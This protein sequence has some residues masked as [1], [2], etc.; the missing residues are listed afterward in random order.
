[1]QVAKDLPPAIAA[2]YARFKAEQAAIQ[3]GN[4]QIIQERQALK[5]HYKLGNS[6]DRDFDVHCQTCKALIPA[7]TKN[8]PCKTEI[9]GDRNHNVKLTTFY[10]C[11][12][13]CNQ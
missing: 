11:P 5:D 2:S 13:G 8:V 4:L 7:H 10:F 3:A 6:K 12:G 1:M 9:L